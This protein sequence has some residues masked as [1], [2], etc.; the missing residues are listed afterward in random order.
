MLRKQ[1][2]SRRHLSILTST[3]FAL[4]RAGLNTSTPFALLRA[5]L[6]TSTL[7]A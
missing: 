5:G 2:R 3:P 6:N 4:L 1:A 7:S